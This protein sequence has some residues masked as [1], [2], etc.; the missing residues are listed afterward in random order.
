ML[1]FQY[2]RRNIM[3]DY[4]LIL[5]QA[6]A[7]ISGHYTAD[8]ANVS[9]LIFSSLENL[10]WAGF[11]FF[12]NETLVLGPF[13]G[14]V[15]CVEIK[16]GKGV[17]GAAADEDRTLIVPDVHK[18]SGHITCDSASRSE[19]VIPLH[20]ENK[21]VGVLDIDSPIYS[22]FTDEDKEGL[23]KLALLIEEKILK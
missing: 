3:T 19:I 6:E 1:F 12:E 21:V 23:E 10:N 14:N 18:F 17:C 13:Q 9:A 15:A 7:L 8:L 4:N 2:V 20:R 16:K 22:R 11:Y 5:K